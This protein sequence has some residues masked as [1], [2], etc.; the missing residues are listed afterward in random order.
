MTKGF[1]FKTGDDAASELSQVLLESGVDLSL[2]GEPGTKTVADLIDEI[3]AGESELHEDN[4]GLYRVANGLGLDVF[5]TI[6][7]QR[8]HLIEDRQVFTNG[9]ERR[10]KLLT[11]LG[12]KI[13]TDE[14][15]EGVVVRAAA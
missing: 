9:L 5:A 12:E 13:K 15:I 14:S 7:G 10:R 2:W 11:S 6:D 4:D 3:N 8:Y 1:E